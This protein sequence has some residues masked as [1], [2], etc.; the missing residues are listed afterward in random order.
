VDAVLIACNA[1]PCVNNGMSLSQQLSH[2]GI[3]LL[4][5][6]LEGLGVTNYALHRMLQMKAGTDVLCL[7]NKVH[8][9][10]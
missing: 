1:G 8:E 6:A 9:G 5:G 10:G 4:A 7:W 3:K 2:I